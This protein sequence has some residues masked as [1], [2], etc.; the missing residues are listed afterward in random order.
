M[1]RRHIE[2]KRVVDR[3][4]RGE[5][6]VREAHDFEQFCLDHPEALRRLPIP[7]SVKAR[8]SRRPAVD[9]DTGAFPALPSGAARAAF[10]A[11]EEEFEEETASRFRAAGRSRV[12]IGGLALALVAAVAGLIIY[13]VQA[14]ALSKQIRSMQTEASATQMQA[15]ASVAIYHVRPVRQR[16]E[17]ATVAPGWFMP[18]QLLDLYIEV[19]DGRHT[20]FQVTID[21]VDSGRLMQI[22]RVARDSNRELRLGLNSSAFG[23]GEYLLKIDG[24]TW[25]GQTEDVGWVRLDLR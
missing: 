7:V 4:L 2:T 25:Q 11:A 12:I 9:S 22:R 8:L 1:D 21:K 13:A 5:M 14:R 16:P 6:T 18:P 23:P 3:Y 24:Y 10:E 20:Q 17:Q 19:A 15:P